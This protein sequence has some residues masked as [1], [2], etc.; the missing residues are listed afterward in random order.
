MNIR[1]IAVVVAAAF[2]NSCVQSPANV[3]VDLTAADNKCTAGQFGSATAKADCFS[4][5]EKPVIQRDIPFAIDAYSIF[6]ARRLSAAAEFDR[7]TAPVQA[8]WKRFNDGT[9]QAA[10]VLIAHEPGF[11][12]GNATLRKE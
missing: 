2:L 8:A 11:A 12:D 6:Q 10:A 1:S 5:V 7:D 9:Q 3:A 4:Q